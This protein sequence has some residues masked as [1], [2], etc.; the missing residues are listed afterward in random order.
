MDWQ[1]RA[2]PGE[3]LRVSASAYNAFLDAAAA[4]KRGEF[5]SEGK[6]RR[7]SSTRIEAKN[8]GAT[9][10]GRWSGC[11]VDGVADATNA[12]DG[13][14][15]LSVKPDTSQSTES[16]GQHAVATRTINPG[17]IGEVVVDGVVVAVASG[18]QQEYAD[19]GNRGRFG[20]GVLF[21]ARGGPIRMLGLVVEETSGTQGFA[22]IRIDS[23]GGSGAVILAEITDATLMSGQNNRWLYD[24][25]EVEVTATGVQQVIGGLTSAQEGKAFN[26]TE[27]VN[28]GREI[29]G[30]GWWVDGAPG[31]FV[32]RPIEEAVVRMERVTDSSGSPRW[33]FGLANVFDG[34][35]DEYGSGSA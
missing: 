1:R 15:V 24:W 21:P 8:V 34:N 18:T 28:D 25:R 30:P 6:G 33:V 5:L 29:E 2:R 32:L 19:A 9:P 10:I 17:M 16:D 22:A 27:L 20:D 4:A 13:R 12:L 11:L 31:T 35:C 23:S 26:L 14:V 3:P 7:E